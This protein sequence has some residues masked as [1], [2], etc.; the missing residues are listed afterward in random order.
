MSINSDNIDRD[1]LPIWGQVIRVV[2]WALMAI[3]LLVYG[4][5]TCMVKMLSPERLTPI[6]VK[7]VNEQTDADFTLG[8]AEL[9]MQPAY[10][11]LAL[12]LDSLCVI[13]PEMSAK[14]IDS[15]QYIPIYADTLLS[16]A[17][18]SGAINLASMARGCIDI[19]DVTIKSPI[20]NFVAVN[21][22]VNNFNVF[23]AIAENDAVSDTESSRVLLPQIVLRRFN[24]AGPALMRYYDISTGLNHNLQIEALLEK[25]SDEQLYHLK[26]GGN[27]ATPLLQSINRSDID[28][29]INCDINWSSSKPYMLKFS[30]FNMDADF[31]KATTN[32]EADFEN[33][34]FIKA[35]DMH[36]EPMELKKLVEL[37]PDSISKPYK[38]ERLETDAKITLTARLDSAFS[39]E[40][41]SIPYA[42]L[43][44]F[45]EP[46]KL[47]YGRSRLNH[48]SAD[49]SLITN[50]NDIDK[51][52]VVVKDLSI[53]G[54][55]TN[56]R[57]SATATNLLKDPTVECYVDGFTNLALLPEQLT[58]VI[59]GY[60]SGKVDMS[61]QARGQLS[62]LSR[63]NFHK[64]KI[65]GKLNANQLFW[66]SAD[67]MNM[68]YV[69]SARFDFG[70]D[71]RFGQ[72]SANLLATIL[73]VDSIDILSGAL[74]VKATG[75]SLGLAS[76]N[77]A[78]SADTSFVN[79]MGGG[80]KV[81]TLDFS[82]IED[83]MGARF[84]NI[85]GRVVF[86]RFKDLKRVPEFIFDLG[87]DRMGAISP[88][89]RML[90]SG[91]KLH[92]SAHK[93][94]HRRPSK[95]IRRLADSIR[96]VHPDLPID[97]VYRL[98]IAKHKRNRKLYHRA[99]SA[100]R[101]S[102]SEIIEWG[103]SP[104]IGKLLLGWRFDGMLSAK[105]ARFYTPHFPLRNRLDNINLSFSNDSITIKDMSY[106]VGRSD[107]LAVGRISNIRKALTKKNA[108]QPIKVFFE[109]VS[110]TVDVNQ[111][112][113][114]FFRG[115]AYSNLHE[116]GSYRTIDI[117][118][119][120]EFDKQIDDPSADSIAPLL[121]PL[122][123]EAEM[124][125]KARNVMY[126]D[127]MLH[128][129]TGDMLVYDGA[130]NLHQLRALSDVGSIDLTA[131][132]SAP[133]LSDI[134]FG[135]GLK[136]RRFDIRRFM[137]LVP[138]LDSIMPLLNDIS[139]IVNA[140]IAATVGIDD[141]MDFKLPTLT[142]AVKLQ[143]D[144][145]QLLDRE[146]FRTVAKWLMFKNK[147]RNII[148]SMTVEMIIAENQMSLFPFIFNID[149]YRL[150]VQGHND[151]ALNFNYLISVLKSPLP[152]KFGITLKGNPDD[153]KIR[154]GR[155]KFNEK[156]AVERKL[157]VDTTRVNLVDQIESVFRRGVRRSK[158][159]SLKLA[160]DRQQSTPIE[161]D[162]PVSSNDSLVFIRE[163]LIKAPLSNND[164][165][166]IHQ[167]RN[168]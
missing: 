117:D 135:F 160:P 2:L 99:T 142:A 77:T 29:A 88:D 103:T 35:F 52:V 66:Q 64:I 109:T 58:K 33:S 76:E 68:A 96:T 82:A 136:V 81:K 50:G 19:S 93:L 25:S 139:G 118:N 147:Q 165:T 38:L 141:K 80:L 115:A 102:I 16:V 65:D 44:M 37:L 83:S 106:K 31:I 161:L 46:C 34:L 148:D 138:A 167:Q 98:A 100:K 41:D 79:P 15:T 125:V 69:N 95:V 153:Y 116:Q 70:T 59:D 159:A 36:I 140:D 6:L 91:S 71:R 61:L 144:S 26:F 127:L 22:S 146:T 105:R 155:A 126:S 53:A 157:I 87:I 47:K 45:I 128:N 166:L 54:P 121:I 104:Y 156:Q 101:D 60:V 55:A 8:R 162:E 3:L 129:L 110:D 149:R 43:S 111:L 143:G 1:K 119:E 17:H 5:L 51:T 49:I 94:P 151:L 132:Y 63:N 124:R 90:F 9:A 97:S 75:L 28:V 18:L 131:L 62:M 10:P 72:S 30:D 130:L 12:S 158:F 84:R 137:E 7:V 120:A 150:G 42:T 78:S 23:G 145:L 39:I 154:I 32:F 11:F 133:E 67:T 20:I 122:N 14:K 74:G 152:F 48:L 4:S 114:A 164:S 73:K 113:D 108:N 134:Q 13:S 24:I 92:F 27:M 89:A 56:I 112:A 86:R 21:D 40:T 123:I 107:F 163:G 85:D 57:L 168:E